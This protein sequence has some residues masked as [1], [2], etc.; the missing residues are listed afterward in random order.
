MFRR[1]RILL[2]AVAALALLYALGPLHAAVSLAFDWLP[3]VSRFRRPVDADFV[4]IAA[5]ALLCGSLLADYIREGVPRRRMIASVA[6]AVAALAMV[7]AGVMFSGRVGHSG[8]A[9]AAALMTRAD[10]GRR[11]PDR[12]RSR[13]ARARARRRGGR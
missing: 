11:D 12:W 6:V 10:C 5:L 4:F 7:A 9:L 13:A 8:D 3:G 2:A 1:G